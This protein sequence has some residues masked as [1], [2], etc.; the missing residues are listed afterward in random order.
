[1]TRR[2]G[3]ASSYGTGQNDTGRTI[4]WPSP[5]AGKR[6]LVTDKSFTG[7]NKYTSIGTSATGTNNAE[8]CYDVGNGNFTEDDR[9]QLREINSEV[10]AL[11]Q[12]VQDLRHE[13]EESNKVIA[14]VKTEN[15]QLRQII[16][17]NVY[18]NDS[19]DQYIRRENLRIYGINE[20]TAAEDDA[21]IVLKDIAIANELKG[22]LGDND[23]QRVHRLGKKP[24]KPNSQPRPIIARFQSYKKR[25]EFFQAKS[26]LKKSEKYS[27]ACLSEDLTPMRAKLLKYVKNECEGRFVQCHTI[28]GKIRMKKSVKEDG[29]ILKDG[30]V[31]KG[32]GNWI[33][34]TSPEDMFKHHI[35][36]NFEK[37]NYHPLLINTVDKGNTEVNGSE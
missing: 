7:T 36:V 21:A 19:L 37:L 13:L 5:A 27:Q 17:L 4:N 25:M 35:D 10:K 8:H 6:Q 15:T 14:E 33:V 18:K 2:N 9:K 3:S 20:S 24:T 12:E 26:S 28:N 22:D 23:I 29:V 11:L 32:T 30:E 16:N 34:V 1:M 31:D